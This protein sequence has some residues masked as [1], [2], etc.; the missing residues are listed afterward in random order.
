V[1]L[2]YPPKAFL[3]G[4]RTLHPDLATEALD[5]DVGRSLGLEPVVAADGVRQ[6]VE[7]HM[8]RAIQTMSIR[9]GIDPRTR[10]MVVGGGAGGL[11]A[12]AL[13]RRLGIE[14]LLVPAEAP[15]LCALGMTV[16][17]VHHDYARLLPSSTA[18]ADLT[19]I[20]Q[21]FDEVDADARHRL[22][23]E[24]FAD[25]DVAM[26]RFVDTW[27]RG[28]ISDLTIPL[29]RLRSQA[30]LEAAA[31]AFHERHR[32]LYGYEC[33][34]LPIEFLHWRLTVRGRNGA[35]PSQ[36]RHHHGSSRA[37]ASRTR[38]RPT[39][40]VHGRTGQLDPRRRRYQGDAAPGP[41]GPAVI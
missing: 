23:D 16:A 31:Q 33:R 22:A 25:A 5:R 14:H 6:V 26:E 12:I 37:A 4:R 3:G 34:D 13:A 24:E 19:A 18:T 11:H 7:A 27:Y 28:Q 2:S 36:P 32:L 38:P 1:V 35:D 9:R 21:L 41:A 20:E 30:T 8:V 39:A 40:G 29:T 17:E 10:T 15:V